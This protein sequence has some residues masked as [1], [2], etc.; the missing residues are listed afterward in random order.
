MSALSSDRARPRAILLIDTTSRFCHVALVRDGQLIDQE[1]T[2]D[3]PADQAPRITAAL[4]DRNRAL[5]EL[6]RI[7]VLTGPGSFTGIRAGMATAM[8]LAFAHKIPLTGITSLQALHACAPDGSDAPDWALVLAAGKAAG[9]GKGLVFYQGMPW[10]RLVR[11]GGRAW[12]KK[13]QAI[14][15]QPCVLIGREP[16]EL[17]SLA[18]IENLH[19]QV[20]AYP[21]LDM[22]RVAAALVGSRTRPLRALYGTRPR[23]TRSGKTR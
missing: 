4:L 10:G 8:G 5:G 22:V 1:I 18:R 6:A 23:I 15:P 2:P 20:C 13:R 17:E 11:L 9:A 19:A 3:K 21:V 14:G 12:Q 7:A 16:Q